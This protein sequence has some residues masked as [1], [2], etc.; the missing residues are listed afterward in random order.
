MQCL[1]PRKPTVWEQIYHELALLVLAGLSNVCGCIEGPTSRAAETFGVYNGG[2][3]R[4]GLRADLAL[5]EKDPLL[6]IEIVR[7]VRNVCV[8][9]V[10][11]DVMV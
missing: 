9:G 8:E 2:A 1:C 4:L 7:A 11:A 10:E 3:V 6:N 5:L